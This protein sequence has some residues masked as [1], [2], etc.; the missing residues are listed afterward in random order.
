VVFAMSWLSQGLS[1]IVLGD[2]NTFYNS[3]IKPALENPVVDVG[4]GLGAPALTGGLASGALGGLFCAADAATT[5]GIDAMTTGEAVDAASAPSL[6][7]AA[8][9]PFAGVQGGG[10]PT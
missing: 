4:F 7:A 9:D 6:S 10:K 2:L 8:T 1:D 3:A 5:G